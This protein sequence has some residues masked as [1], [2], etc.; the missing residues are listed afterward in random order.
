MQAGGGGQVLLSEATA[1][2]VRDVLPTDVGLVDLGERRFRGIARPFGVYALRGAG[3]RD[4]DGFE[5]S[6]PPSGAHVLAGRD[7]ELAALRAAFGAAAAG[8]PTMVLLVGEAGIGKT[9]LAD[10][11]AVMARA[12]GMR[13]LRGEADPSVR[14]PMELWRGVYRSLDVGP[15]SDPTLPA[16][17]RRWEHLESLAG[18]L[19][20]SAPAV[21]VLEDLHWADA[22]AV[23]VLEHLPRALGDCPIALVATSRDHQPDMPRLDAL[24]RVSRLVQLGGLDVEA[25]RQLAAEQATRSVD[26]VELHARTGGNPLFVRELLH[27]PDDGGV[28]DEV[29]DRSLARFDDGTRALL[30]AAAL[31]GPSTPLAVLA[32]A[33]DELGAAMTPLGEET[34]ST[35]ELPASTVAIVWVDLSFPTKGRIPEQISH[36]LT[37]DVGPGLPVGP[38]ITDSGAPAEVSTQ[39]AVVIEPPLLDGPWVAAGGAVGPHRRALQAINGHLRL[40]QRF[41]V[42]FATLLDDEGRSHT[43]DPDQNSSYFNY[44]QP[45]LAVG[46][47]TMVDAVDGLP[48]QT[49]N[50]NTPIPLAEAGGNEVILR[51]DTGIYV[52]YGHFKPGSLRV[53][54]GQHVRPGEVLGEIGNSGNSTGPHL[55]LQLMTDPS[56]PDADGLP[57]VIRDFRFDGS[58]PSLDAL[59]EADLAGTPMPIDAAHAGDRRLQGITGLDVVTFP[60]S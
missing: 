10:E 24:R 19:I 18:A 2:L 28:I 4:G 53:E 27:A 39:Q 54:P 7:G 14:E 34:G 3:L 48:D 9:R 47:G 31:A 23:W 56:F 38:T 8:R 26:A 43:G 22:M 50:H 1:S 6:A 35:T 46:A 49:P 44:G 30:A 29:L 21:V 40:S 12:A 55:H 57:F 25:V 15:V 59:V 42:D 20:S 17:E 32:A 60:S 58:V 11:A 5:L 13:V 41:A 51:L 52:G 45:V 33:G 36:Q 37:V 16:E